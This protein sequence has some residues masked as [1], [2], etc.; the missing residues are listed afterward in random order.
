MHV[1]AEHGDRCDWVQNALAGPVAVWIDGQRFDATA[2]MRPDL[3]PY[4]VWG[5][6]RGRVVVAFA[7]WLAHEP[8]VVELQLSETITI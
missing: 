6:M 4:R 7:K 1:V 3:A 2:R 5:A 8:K